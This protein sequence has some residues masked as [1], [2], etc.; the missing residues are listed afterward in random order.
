MADSML[1]KQTN[2]LKTSPNCNEDCYIE[3]CYFCSQYKELDIRD[4][5]RP[6]IVN[7]YH[8]DFR[9]QPEST[10]P[11]FQLP[12]MDRN[13]MQSFDYYKAPPTSGGDDNNA[14]SYIGDNYKAPSYVGEP[15]TDMNRGCECTLYSGDYIVKVGGCC[16]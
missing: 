11:K 9:V 6:M 4:N 15:L 16:R 3:D 8:I 5:Q 1:R 14:P 13:S 7:N 2:C 10:A 12:I